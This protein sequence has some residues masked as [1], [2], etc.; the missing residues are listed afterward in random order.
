[1]RWVS[2][3]AVVT[4]AG[5]ALG[6]TSAQAD[7]APVLVVPARPDVP[8]IVDGYDASWAIVEGDWGLHRPG[9][10]SPRVTYPYPVV[11]YGYRHYFPATGKRPRIGRYEIVPPANRRLPEPAETFHRYWST[12]PEPTIVE[13]PPLNPP[14]IILAPKYEPPRHSVAPPLRSLD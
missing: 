14:P 4:L 7:H 3:A 8:V 6:V 13:Y 11:P 2:W 10:V 9:W 1:M 5:W 12:Q